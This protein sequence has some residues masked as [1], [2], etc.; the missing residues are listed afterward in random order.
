M[1]GRTTEHERECR[2]MAVIVI[3]AMRERAKRLGYALGVHGSL[4]YD[5]DVIAAP[6]RED[7]VA[8]PEELKEAILK[9]LEG[10]TGYAFANPKEAE[11]KPHGRLAWSLHFGGGPYVDLSVMPTL[12][13][14]A[15]PAFQ[16]FPMC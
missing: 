8:S 9:C 16:F 1:A 15:V 13:K 12:P 10:I 3:P 7:C 5:I 11:K 14:K 4:G 6:W 2:R